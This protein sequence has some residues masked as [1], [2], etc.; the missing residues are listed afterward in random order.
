MYTKYFKR[1]IDIILALGVLVVAFIPMLIIAFLI[2]KEDKESPFF[3]Q[4][5]MGLNEVP[6]KMIK[7]RSMTTNRTEL[8][9]KLTHEQMV[10]KIGRIIRKTSL[11]ELPQIFNVLK[12]EMSFIGPRPWILPYY[13]WMTPVQKRRVSV[14]PGLTGYAQIRGRNGISV[15]KKI[16]YDLEYINHMSLKSDLYIV[17]ESIKIVAKETNAEITEKGITEEIEE[18]KNNPKNRKKLKSKIKA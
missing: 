3:V 14:R 16:E 8:E 7:F 11:D 15:S 17:K 2:W 13:E 12:G 6:F 10:T 9:G 5:R 4:D 18:L 1:I